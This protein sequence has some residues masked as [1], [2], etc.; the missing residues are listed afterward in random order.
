Q[1]S[2]HGCGMPRARGLESAR[3]SRS[4]RKEC[5]LIRAASAGVSAAK[6]DGLRR[7][8]DAAHAERFDRCMIV[9]QGARGISGARIARE[10]IR[11]AA[12]AA[13]VDSTPLAAPARLAHPAFAAK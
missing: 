6:H 10:Q 12:T 1:L 4:R 11:L 2:S 13:E 8:S 3:A 5:V 7:A 9:S